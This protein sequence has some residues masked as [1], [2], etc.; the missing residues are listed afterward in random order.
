MRRAFP[1]YKG[2]LAAFLV[3]I[4]AM[5]FSL[6]LADGSISGMPGEIS[7]ETIHKEKKAEPHFES[8]ILHPVLPNKDL[9]YPYTLI[10]SGALNGA[11]D[12]D[13]PS[14]SRSA[15]YLSRKFSLDLPQAQ[16]SAPIWG[17]GSGKSYLIPAFEVPVYNLIQ[18]AIARLAYHHET[19]TRG[20]KVYQTDLSTFWDN[21]AHGTWVIDNDD[22]KT[23]QIRHPYQGSIYQGLARSA[24]LSFWE[25]V[26]YTLIGSFLWET[27][28]ENTSPSINDQ[29]A[30]GV[31]G[32]FLGEALFRM[33]S[34]V[35]EHGE[36]GFWREL[37]A[38]VISPPTG[39]NRHAFGERFK[40]IFPS[41]HPEVFWRVR[42]GGTWNVYTSGGSS[43]DF[44]RNE[45]TGNFSLI[46]GLPGKPG[47][48]YTRPFDY[49]EFEMT[50]VSND[51]NPLNPV[52]NLMT[53][54]LLVGKEYEAG[55]S[56]RG[57]WGLY[58]SYDYMFPGTL[59]RVSTTALSLGTTGQWWLARRAALQG[60]VLAGVGY[61]A[62]GSA[63][64]SGKR[65]YHYGL[66]GQGLLSVR[67]ILAEA[68]MLEASLREYYISDQASSSPKGN[69]AI[70]YLNLGLT[71]RLH[72][73]H[74]LQ[75]QWL[76]YSRNGNYSGM[77]AQHQQM[78][79]FALLYT[80]LSDTNFGV[81]E[82]RQG[83]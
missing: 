5:N 51:V 70:G 66:T 40:G 48:P 69:E 24:G 78:A 77:E 10:P 83:R 54:G 80:F 38:A 1:A 32:N 35:L 81:V 55:N 2:T 79:R 26:P 11:V 3:F 76:L 28:G 37:A 6:A 33:A 62:G 74:A 16:T 73:R 47:Y 8:G 46:H 53:Y 15:I 82:W 56:Y 67:L 75:A 25:S 68:A 61:G 36:P 19:T 14:H 59:M 42:L 31:A 64:P 41:R 4:S 39:F 18:N 49:F 23:N 20:E 58:G 45:A 29:I 50:A 30:S 21:L 44:S 72:E 43:T 27:G 22:F 65:N 7:G 57:I 34:L 17:K 71:V 63:P 52:E 13:P 12:S 9:L 60:S